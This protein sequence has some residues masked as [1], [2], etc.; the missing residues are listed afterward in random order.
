MK[1]I[2]IV[3]DQSFIR[4]LLKNKLEEFSTV[5]AAN[6]NEAMGKAKFAKPDLILLDIVMPKKD[7]IEV[8]KDLQ[9]NVETRNIPVIVIS[10]HAEDE[11]RS[12]ALEFGAKEFVDKADI[13]NTDILALVKKYI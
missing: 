7:G 5:E 8:L 10:S 13:Q 1:K 6:G 12:Q 9:A 2:L 11:K 3:D 4:T